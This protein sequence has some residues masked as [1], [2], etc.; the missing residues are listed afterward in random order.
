MSF[1][2]Y[3]QID[4][5]DYG[6]TCVK[7]VSKYYNKVHSIN[8]LR[9]LSNTNRE[10]ITLLGLSDLA[11]KIGFRTLSVKLNLIAIKEAVLPCILHWNKN[12][13]VILYKIKNF[14][15]TTEYSKL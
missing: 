1:P 13:Y 2:S 9:A 8:H 3:L 4:E 10:G 11:E 6:V 5:K 14:S 7:I 15:N 12:H